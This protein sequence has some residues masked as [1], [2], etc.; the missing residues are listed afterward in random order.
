MFKKIFLALILLFAGTM[1][2]S[3]CPNRASALELGKDSDIYK[4]IIRQN[5]KDCYLNEPLSN[6]V[7][8]KNWPNDE[9]KSL[10]GDSKWVN[11]P[12]GYTPL[13]E[14]KVTCKG[15]MYGDASGSG[16]KG[17]YDGILS[18]F[19]KS[20]NSRTGLE[21]KKELAVGFGYEP[22]KTGEL[23]NSN[24]P[25][26]FAIRYTYDETY[27]Y[28]P[29]CGLL[30]LGWCE[31]YDAGPYHAATYTTGTKVDE[32]G[33]V[34]SKL[35]VFS[36]GDGI[37]LQEAGI[38]YTENSNKSGGTLT[39]NCNTFKKGWDTI[40]SEAISGVVNG[41]STE[42]WDCEEGSFPVLYGKTTWND[43]D[44]K[45]GE[46]STANSVVGWL[47]KH[48]PLDFTIVR[49]TDISS[50]DPE[51]GSYTHS[52]YERKNHFTTIGVICNDKNCSSDS[53]ITLP[54]SYTKIARW[55]DRSVKGM[56]Y[57]TGG[58][59]RIFTDAE[60]YVLYAGYLTDY[61]KADFQC[62]SDKTE[63]YDGREGYVKASNILYEGEMQD[64]CYV[65]ATANA[66]QKVNGVS[67]Y[68]F[69]GADRGG[70]MVFH[71]QKT[72]EELLN[73]IANLNVTP[74][75]IA[76]ANITATT[77]ENENGEVEKNCDNSAGSLG[78]ILCP[79]LQGL[80]D[81]AN[82]AWEN[83][84]QPALEIDTVL[85]GS[86]TENQS[87]QKVQSDAAEK[88]WGIFRNISNVIFIIF[89]LVI[90]F[91]QLTG[92]GIDN[93]GIKKSLPKLIVAAI[94]VN[95]SFLIC[96]LAVDLSNIFGGSLYNLMNDMGR[97]ILTESTVTIDGST[98]YMGAGALT[99]V[100]ILV[101]IAGFVGAFWQNGI[102]VLIP[103]LVGALSVAISIAFLFILLSVRQAGVVVLVI[104][105]PIA[106]VAYLMP[107]S[108]K[109]FDK[110]LKAFEGLLLLYPI[111]GLLVGGGN[112][113]SKL[114]LSTGVGNTSFFLALTAM[115]VGIAPIFFIP[116]LLKGAFAAIGNIGNT[117]SNLGNRVGKGVSS[118]VGDRAKNSESLRR[119]DNMLGRHSLSR[120]RRARAAADTAAYTKERAERDRL[121][122]RKNMKTRIDSIAAAEEAKAVDEATAQ[123]L[124]LMMSAGDKGGITLRNKD[125]STTRGAFTLDNAI[126]RVD[127]LR[128]ASEKGA[129]NNEEKLEL[130]ALSRGL[131]GMKG[132]G[133][134]KLG[135]AIREA[136]RNKMNANFMSAMG[137]IYARDS[138]VKDKL[139][140]K[141]P[142]SAVLTEQFIPGTNPDNQPKGSFTD[143][144]RANEATISS[145]IK[146]YSAGL[147]QGGAA[148][149][150][151]VNS[152][153]TADTQKVIDD[154]VLMSGLD[155][156][157][158]NK[159]EAHA[160]S[161]GVKRSVRQVEV[162][163]GNTA[164][165]NTQ[166]TS[167]SVAASENETFKVQNHDP[168]LDVE[169]NSEESAIYGDG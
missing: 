38:T 13:E 34:A 99:C 125:G 67:S 63:Y 133:A 114:L 148:L 65:K 28:R 104:V 52:Q 132:G 44:Y 107:N 62:G 32:N 82:E 22:S 25:M 2:V 150:E 29:G 116:T 140:E 105:S 142:A 12:T 130:A 135:G 51:G 131:A 87:G 91:S 164:P 98:G 76:E 56:E 141:D 83:Y 37:D 49:S 120:R 151:F 109:L 58:T 159:V 152:L 27:S 145:R 6:K 23:D 4:K 158:R 64:V 156:D 102:A 36:S 41:Y 57:F 14:N 166:P 108:K 122:N 97:D 59:N 40:L 47:K 77:D 15:F 73:Q 95:L 162:V 89:F 144:Q 72:F 74:E 48:L 111:C 31:E 78:W 165:A 112:F 123:R 1:A 30:W 147:N 21:T 43:G 136:N 18:I 54:G 93:Y 113:V 24:A 20:I 121:S 96:Q 45:N 3:F 149:D 134:S 127:Q 79:I 5:I 50:G 70:G 129:L 118:R 69:N 19:G 154:D 39:L 155:I 143:F 117:I 35:E 115:I 42:D 163:G 33:A 168:R 84:I 60:I 103:L 86:E 80:A 153:S 167:T 7:F 68:N 92:V 157:A 138:A 124:S 94:L 110:W 88:A 61:Y 10:F 16:A 100:A 106:F 17:Q 8:P 90:I 169:L 146:T 161:L 85:L 128:E 55:D 46:S 53:S 139:G 26:Y 75:S 119:F 11:M 126:A 137:E 9:Y 71:G 66:S 160:K 81:A 101:A